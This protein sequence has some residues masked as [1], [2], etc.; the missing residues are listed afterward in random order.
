MKNLIISVLFVFLIISCGKNESSGESED[1][2][3]KLQETPQ[4]AAPVM[5]P[6]GGYFGTDRLVIITTETSGATIYYTLDG[7]L[8]NE[9]SD[10]YR[11]SIPVLGNG[12]NH[13]IR[14]YAV[15]E[16]MLDSAIITENFIINYPRVSTPSFNLA[17][18]NYNSNQ[19]VSINMQTIGATVYFTTDGTEPDTDSDV[20]DD[21]PI[22][23]AGNGTTKV[24]KAYGVKEGMTDSFIVTAE[25][26]IDYAQLPMPTFSLSG[27]TFTELQSVQINVS[28]GATLYYTTDGSVPTPENGLQ[29]NPVPIAVSTTI[30]AR[31][32]KD[33]MEES[34]VA[35]RTYNLKVPTP[36][37]SHGSGEYNQSFDLTISST[38]D[39]A[40]IIYTTDGTDPSLTNGWTY[41]QPIHISGV[42][43]LTVK[44]F[45]TGWESSEREFRYY[46]YHVN[47]P[48]ISASGGHYDAP[49]SVT[50]ECNTLDSEIKYTLDGSDP[51]ETNGNVYSEAI[52][53]GQDTNL[54]VIAIKNN[55][56]PSDVI[57]E[58]Y[59]FPTIVDAPIFSLN[60]GNYYE[61]QL[62]TMFTYLPGASI[63]YTTDGSSPSSENGI[64]YVGDPVQ[65]TVSTELK[66]A[67]HKLGYNDSAISSKTYTLLVSRST[68]APAMGVLSLPRT[69]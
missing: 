15:K 67:T 32:Y 17:P 43:T 29:V 3:S 28:P 39:R 55:W 37:F 20:Y 24:I 38:T 35:E 58:S 54:K 59:T 26:E 33:G 50:I 57:E 56:Y 12:S 30:R 1:G 48:V 69:Y 6:N 46:T 40:R 44:V 16:E 41:L 42:T 64:L 22:E 31:V 23:I 10:V 7:S 36:L 63:Y 4:V 8:P 52:V 60:G 5:S 49:Q 27:G 21:T 2:N 47:N 13:I 34:N 45:K 14:A 68:I 65:I 62:V 51:S 53:I 19:S 25:Y 18:G 11:S 9:S 66:A 61:E